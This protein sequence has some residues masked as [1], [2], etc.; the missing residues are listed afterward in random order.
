MITCLLIIKEVPNKGFYVNM[1]P[2]D[3]KLGSEIER[4][5]AG[6]YDRALQLT[7][8]LI[9]RKAN[10]GEMLEGKDFGAIRSLIQR[11]LDKFEFGEP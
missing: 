10:N 6:V 4:Q 5:V 3:P 11:E 9:M 2:S 8:E 1:K 7:G